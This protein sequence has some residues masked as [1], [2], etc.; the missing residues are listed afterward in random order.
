MTQ[1]EKKLF[2]V[3]YIY[4]NEYIINNRKIVLSYL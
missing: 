3:F 4:S 1:V 2:A